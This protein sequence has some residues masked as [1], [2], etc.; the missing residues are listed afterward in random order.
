MKLPK[1][2]TIA[3]HKVDIEVKKLDIADYGEAKPDEHKIYISED[4]DV[5]KQIEILWHEA[6]HLALAY[7]GIGY[8]LEEKQEESF[9]R[10]IQFQMF[11][12][13]E[14]FASLI[15]KS[16]RKKK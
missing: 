6:G 13:V 5:R 7:G 9:V 8:Q 3:G 10:L 4:I 11:P 12:L 16:K 2:L 15:K 1:H 14:Q